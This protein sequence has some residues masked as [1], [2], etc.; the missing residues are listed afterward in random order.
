[1]HYC[2]HPDT[3]M[4]LESFGLKLGDNFVIFSTALPSAEDLSRPQATTEG[5]RK[6]LTRLNAEGIGGA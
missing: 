3:V 2:L 4:E 1:M 5:V 6:V